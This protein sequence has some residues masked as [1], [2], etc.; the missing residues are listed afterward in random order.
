[1]TGDPVDPK[2][3]T[4]GWMTD[5]QM[6]NKVRMLMRN[7]LEHEAVCCGARDRIM[8]LSQQLEKAMAR[9]AH[10]ER[11]LADAAALMQPS[12]MP[13]AAEAVKNL[14]EQV[15]AAPP[16]P[17]QI[18]SDDT[19]RMDWL[20]RQAEKGVASFNIGIEFE[21]G[22]YLE[23]ADIG[24]KV[25]TAIREANSIREAVDKA[26]VLPLS[27]EKIMKDIKK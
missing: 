20:D 18:L 24:D 27:I 16:S 4:Y 17:I 9:T 22:V 2:T 7:T 21:G 10:L 6:A 26:I 25:T 1:M 19:K 5:L 12:E 11:C 3:M 23:F 8:L 15:E 13:D 14:T